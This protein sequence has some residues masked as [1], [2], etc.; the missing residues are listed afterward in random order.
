MF[1]PKQRLYAV[2][3]RTVMSKKSSPKSFLCISASCGLKTYNKWMP[4]NCS[5]RKNIIFQNLG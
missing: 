3:L 1:L 2:H 4:Q 5:Q